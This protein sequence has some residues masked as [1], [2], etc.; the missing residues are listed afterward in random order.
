M[1]ARNC[2][3]YWQHADYLPIDTVVTYWCEK[4]GFRDDHCRDAKKAA[5]CSAVDRKDVRFKRSDGKTFDDGAYDMAARGILLIERD[6]FNAWADQFTDAPVIEKPFTTKERGNLLNIIGAL[7]EELSRKESA[8]VDGIS[9]RHK[10]KGGLSAR[11][12]EGVFAEAKR[13]LNAN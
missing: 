8:I 11:N 5:I 13:N 4:S 3:Y 9:T 7:L 6:S 2:D 1:E 10:G 12:L